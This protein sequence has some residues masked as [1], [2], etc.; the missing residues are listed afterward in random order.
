PSRAPA[1]SPGSGSCR[2]DV[3]RDRGIIVAVGTVGMNI[4]RKLYYEKD[5][6]FRVSRSYGPGR[7]DTA[8]EQK[9][10]DYPIGY[11]RWTENRNMDAFLE[12]LADGK[13]NVRTLITHRVTIERPHAYEIITARSSEPFLDVLITYP[14][15]AQQ[16]PRP[17]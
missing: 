16:H 10:R 11:A 3:A 8:Y 2:A 7:Y 17:E 14:E 13:I 6:D 9:G 12:L 15:T 1:Q 4:Q 5:L